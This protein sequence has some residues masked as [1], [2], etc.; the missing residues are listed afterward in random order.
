[1]L[2]I[3]LRRINWACGRINHRFAFFLINN[4]TVW[5][6]LPFFSSWFPLPNS[7]IRNK[8]P[9]ENASWHRYQL[10]QIGRQQCCYDRI[11]QWDEVSES[12][13]F[14]K[15]WHEGPGYDTAVLFSLYYSCSVTWHWF[16]KRKSLGLMKTISLRSGG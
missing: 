6:N 13:L 7:L 8:I 5:F 2:W 3:S 15:G 1:M 4:I 16:R 11:S 10:S 9:R 14:S 12:R